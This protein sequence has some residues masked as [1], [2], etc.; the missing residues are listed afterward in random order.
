M[1]VILLVACELFTIIFGAKHVLKQVCDD[2]LVT[3]R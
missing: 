3:R 2:L 1:H